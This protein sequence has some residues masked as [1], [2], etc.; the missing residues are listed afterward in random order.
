MPR[1]LA[2]KD[3]VAFAEGDVTVD[4]TALSEIVKDAFLLSMDGRV[5]ESV[6]DLLNGH[7]I[8]LRAQLRDLLGKIFQANTG[9]LTHANETITAV[10]VGLKKAKA[11]IDKVADTI[12]QLGALVGQ[13]DALLKIAGT[14]I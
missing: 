2:L 6:Q 7:G 1:P 5:S 9:K 14:V 10:N 13:L 3:G 8:A 4:T 12:E 11:D